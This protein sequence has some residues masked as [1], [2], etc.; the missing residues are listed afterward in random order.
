VTGTGSQGSSSTGTYFLGTD[1]TPQGVTLDT[2]T[3]GTLDSA[4]TQQYGTLIV[5][6]T[7]LFHL[8]LTT[9]NTANEAVDMT[10][11]DA[12][13]SLVGDVFVKAGESASLTLTLAPGR[14]RFRY[15]AIRT[16][17]GSD[18]L[19]VS[20]RLKGVLLDDPLGPTPEDSTG[21]GSGGYTGD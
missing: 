7:G 9:G 13:G 6:Q 10:I 5:G 17:G 20:Y 12:N 19:P 8:V 4:R 14:Y 3:T 18:L 1:F 16:D 21:T 15:T 11:T 2:F